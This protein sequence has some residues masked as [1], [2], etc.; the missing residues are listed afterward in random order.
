M[1][2]F[3]EKFSGLNS[4]RNLAFI[5]ASIIVLATIHRL[6]LGEHTFNNF[7]IFRFSF[8]TL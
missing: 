3:F 4:V 1:D 5:F 2:K 8:S 6:W 7:S